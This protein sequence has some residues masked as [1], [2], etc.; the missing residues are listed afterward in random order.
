MVEQRQENI[1]PT[2]KMGMAA[3]ILNQEVAVAAKAYISNES[4]GWEK[5]KMC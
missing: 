4:Q 5:H 1:N 2:F 3:L